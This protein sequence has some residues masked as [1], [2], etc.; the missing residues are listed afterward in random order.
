MRFRMAWKNIAPIV[1]NV[2]VLL[3][4]MKP[5][6]ISRELPESQTTPDG[7]TTETTGISAIYR[8]IWGST[9]SFYALL[10]I[11]PGDIYGLQNRPFSL[12]YM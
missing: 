12:Y 7:E 6:I 4:W 10:W 5:G 2:A 8:G 9:R 1:R 11:K 3:N